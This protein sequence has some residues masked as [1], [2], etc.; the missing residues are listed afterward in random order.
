[1]LEALGVGALA[2]ASLIIGAAAATAVK[3]PRRAVGLLL[4]FG[5]GALISSLAFELAEEAVKLSGILLFALGLALG[6]LTF[7]AGD[8]WLEARSGRR[9]PHRTAASSSGGMTLAL[10]ALLDGIP[11]QAVLGI[12][13][14]AGESADVALLVAVFISNLPEA[15][16]SA[17]QM[18]RG[19]AL[20]LWAVVALVCVLATV[21]GYAL[22]DGASGELRGV[23]DAFAAGA[24]LCML[25]DSMI[26]E[27]RKQGGRVTGLATMIGFAVAVALSQA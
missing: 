25:I 16:G 7:Y 26:P 27:A 18:E 24:V 22:L 8:R 6:A 1:L 2:A 4:A 19:R 12:G 21:A 15:I 9:R 23:V 11:E 14:A 13:L 17:A 3:L 10:G 5:A 20:R